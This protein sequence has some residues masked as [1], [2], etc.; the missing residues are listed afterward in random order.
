[1]GNLDDIIFKYRNRD[2]GAYQLR[3]KSAV[4]LII[5]FSISVVLF[6]TV[7]LCFFVYDHLP[8]HISNEYSINFDKNIFKSP[9]LTDIKSETVALAS[10]N[11]FMDTKPKIIDDLIIID[12]LTKEISNKDQ[13]S[14][15]FADKNGGESEKKDTLSVSNMNIVKDTSNKNKLVMLIDMPPMFPNGENARVSFIQKNINYPSLA[16][17]NNI[18][19]LVFVEFIVEADSSI[20]HIKISQGIGWGCDEEAIRLIKTMPKWIPCMKNN[21]PIRCQ[22]TMPILFTLDSL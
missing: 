13:D 6:C 16:K 2:Y 20:T 21:R 1:M 3:K 22:L 14:N 9:Y 10:K 18:E 15:S 4:F 17:E 19:G 5:S 8:D 7:I 11:K 12:T